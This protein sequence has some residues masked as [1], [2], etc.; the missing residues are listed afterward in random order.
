MKRLLLTGLLL[1][2]TSIPFIH[3]EAIE[4]EEEVQK[5]SVNIHNINY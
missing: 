4:E 2:L 1:C 3:A 5:R